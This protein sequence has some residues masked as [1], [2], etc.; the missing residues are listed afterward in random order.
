MAQRTTVEID[1]GVAWIT[2][3]DGKVNAMSA[4]MLRDVERALDAAEEAG[5]VAVLTGRTGMFSAGFDLGTFK[6]GADAARSMVLA[7]ARLVERL[8]AFPRPVLAGCTGHAY[9][10]GAF[11]LLASD[12]RF[13]VRGPW[14]T[15]MNEVAIGLTVPLFAIEI[16]RHRLSPAGFARITSAAMFDP[17]EAAALGY[18]DRVL[19]AEQLRDELRVEAARLRALDGASY[20]AT[21]ERVNQRARAAIRAAIESELAG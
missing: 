13:G 21:K 1:D 14:R 18:L 12:V 7:G 11:L 20:V 19:P 5:A 6:Q 4:D 2:L 8:L 17:D 15:G 10:M 16:A 3:D 9:P